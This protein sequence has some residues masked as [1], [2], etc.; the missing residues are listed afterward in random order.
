MFTRG[1]FTTNDFT[2]SSTELLFVKDIKDDVHYLFDKITEVII[3]YLH[4]ILDNF[5]QSS[6]VCML[7][8]GLVDMDQVCHLRSLGISWTE[9]AKVLGVSRMSLYRKRKEAVITSLLLQ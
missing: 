7:N 1:V 6:S 4:P 8:E 9:I 2:F 5:N 3:P